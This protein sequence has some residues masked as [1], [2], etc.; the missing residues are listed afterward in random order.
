M[1][2]KRVA[3]STAMGLPLV[4][5]QSLA[6]SSALHLP[7]RSPEVAL[8]SA[9]VCKRQGFCGSSFSAVSTSVGR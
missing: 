3:I 5:A 8:Q 4:S 7:M 6:G 2:L 9:E 1:R